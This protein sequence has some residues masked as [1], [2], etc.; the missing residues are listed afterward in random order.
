MTASLGL[1]RAVAQIE[2]SD[3][4][5]LARLLILLHSASG[6]KR[7]KPVEGIMKLAKLDFLLRYPNCLERVMKKESLKENEWN[8]LNIKEYEK[9]NVEASMI[10][11]RYGPWDERYRKWIGLLVAKGLARTY[12]KGKT[13]NISLTERGKSMAEALA[14]NENFSDIASRSQLLM[15]SSVGKMGATKLKDY[16]YQTFPEILDMRWGDEI[17]L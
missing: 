1:V 8:K 14:S 5:H 7:E 17:S 10:R 9:D 3:D 13:I 11:F 6:S 16:V 2:R 15:S 12:M 4:W